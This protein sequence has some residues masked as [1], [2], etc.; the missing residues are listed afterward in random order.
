MPNGEYFALRLDGGDITFLENVGGGEISGEI[1]HETSKEPSQTKK[2]VGK[3]QYE[4]F[5]MQIGSTVSQALFDWI[6]NS[7]TYTAPKQNGAILICDSNLLV[8]EERKF[9]KAVI[10][11]LTIPALDVSAENIGNVRIRFTPNRIDETK[12]SKEKPSLGALANHR[13]WRTSTFQ[14]DIDGLESKCIT[15]IESFTVMRTGSA[16][17]GKIEYPNLKISLTKSGSQSWQ[18]WFESFVIRGKNSDRYEKK[19]TIRFLT[20]DGKSELSH[21]ELSHLG[22]F[23]LSDVSEHTDQT[24]EL[25]AELYCEWMGFH[26]RR[27]A[28]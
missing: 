16:R 5:T 20:P 17:A 2:R 11:E 28:A 19:G 6:A 22:I 27:I 13:L 18:E 1:K 3:I 24:A 9:T 21:I 4:D 26:L 8:E 12:Y 10:Q 7:W 23:R 15:R 14:L 25:Q